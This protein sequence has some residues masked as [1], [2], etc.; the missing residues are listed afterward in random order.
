MGVPCIF[1]GSTGSM[2][3]EHIFPHWMHP[4]LPKSG[5]EN[6]TRKNEILRRS[7]P[8]TEI[9][10][11]SGEPFSG[12]LRIVCRDCNN[13]W[14]S[15][16]QEEAKPIILPLILGEPSRLNRRGQE[17]LA[18]WVTMFVFV[19]EYAGN[20]P[21]FVM[22]TPEER[23]HLMER[24]E[25]PVGWRIWIGDYVRGSWVGTVVHTTV[26]VAPDGA[27][28]EDFEGERLKANVGSTTFVANR[29]FVSVFRSRIP[30][31]L[32]KQHLPRHTYPRLWPI[33]RGALNWPPRR[34]VRDEDAD[35]ISAA[36]A[37]RSKTGEA[38]FP[39]NLD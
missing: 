14:M 13:G 3:K 5:R 26:P 12:A 39:D 19:S 20:H 6:H 23:R 30:V 17:L 21:L 11:R 37:L 35:A 33:I 24:R 15:K 31:I 28:K 16:L 2:S 7:G 27:S 18:A 9:I 38:A 25:P 4:Y 32:S 34:K 29:L 36:L 8:D 10:T 1:C 22:A